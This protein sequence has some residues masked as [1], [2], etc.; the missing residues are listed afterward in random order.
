MV[1]SLIKRQCHIN[2][3]RVRND[4]WMIWNDSGWI[5]MVLSLIK[6]QCHI[7]S[8]RVR[9]DAWMIWNDS[10]LINMVLSLIKRQCH[11]NSSRVRN[12]AGMMILCKV[13]LIF[14][15]NRKFG[16]LSF[17]PHSSFPCRFEMTERLKNEKRQ[18]LD[19]VWLAF[20]SFYDHFII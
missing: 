6:R 8:S 4:A 10:G 15:F 20:L 17:C 19:F 12:D 3:S 14:K 18:W 11:I 7:N 1:L 5:N 2:S 13:G 9:N 16:Q